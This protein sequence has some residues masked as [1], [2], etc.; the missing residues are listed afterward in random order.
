[1]KAGPSP[2]LWPASTS[3]T[4]LRPSD[5]CRDDPAECRILRPS[6]RMRAGGC[7][8]PVGRE[9]G[10]TLGPAVSARCAVR[11]RSTCRPGRPI[12]RPAPGVGR[13]AAT[14]RGEA[15]RT[16]RVRHRADRCSTPLA[17][18][19]VRSRTE[20]PSGVHRSRARHNGRDLRGC[21]LS[22]VDWYHV[23]LGLAD[24]RPIQVNEGQVCKSIVRI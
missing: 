20:A 13:D 17:F 21:G 5:L 24:C 22:R 19:P 11:G 15:G 9:A 4:A 7:D 8:R 18:D 12:R 10:G 1:M 23:R 14:R 16:C 2:G 6:V 3:R